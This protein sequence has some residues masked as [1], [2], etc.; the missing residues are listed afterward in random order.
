MKK[1]LIIF[2]NSLLLNAHPLIMIL[3]F[4]TQL[5]STQRRG[6]LPLLVKTIIR[7]LD[8]SKTHGFDDI[9]IR[10][11]KLCDDSLVKPL[12]KAFQKCINSGVFP[13]SW[14]KSNIVP[15]HKKNDKQLINNYR[16][17]SLLAICSKILERI[18]F[19][20]IFQFIEENKLLN[21][22]QSGFQPGDSCEYQLL[23][24]V[25]NIYAGFD[26]NPPL[27]VL[28]CFLDISKAFDKRWHEGLFFFF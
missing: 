16:P 23:S 13:D 19:N 10:M 15:I 28:S 14:K 22:N 3:K 27:E 24:I 2:I 9:S 5:F 25:H 12:S 11:V 6:F 7:N 1:K 20:S 8:I 26:Q 21:G 18:I 17:V 4:L